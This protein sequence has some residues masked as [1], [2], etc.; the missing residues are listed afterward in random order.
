MVIHSACF[1][2]AVSLNTLASIISR[3]KFK[4]PM[5]TH[6][7]SQVWAQCPCE[8]NNVLAINLPSQS[9]ALTCRHTETFFASLMLYS[10]IGSLQTVCLNNL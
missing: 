5:R 3:R 7:I 9:T 2:L 1:M 10:N 6:H 4:S 8:H